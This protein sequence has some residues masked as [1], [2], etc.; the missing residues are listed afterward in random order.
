MWI[1]IYIVLANPYN[2]A[3]TNSEVFQSKKA[4]EN[5][6]AVLESRF[7]NQFKGVCVSEG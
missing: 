4:C 5:A 3:A 6:L 7:G 2:T 1:L